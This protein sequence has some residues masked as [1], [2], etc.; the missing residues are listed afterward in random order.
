MVEEFD[1]ENGPK[2]SVKS[3]KTANFEKKSLKYFFFQIF[4]GIHITLIE[5][6]FANTISVENRF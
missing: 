6:S 4:L 3:L 5:F 2:W 1:V